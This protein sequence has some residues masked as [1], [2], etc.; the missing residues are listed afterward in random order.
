[1]GGNYW[2]DFIGAGVRLYLFHSALIGRLE[3][4]RKAG[5]RSLITGLHS[6]LDSVR[7]VLSSPLLLRQLRWPWGRITPLPLHD[8]HA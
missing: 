1:M 6:T 8:P 2:G 3:T 7:L 4:Q 5:V